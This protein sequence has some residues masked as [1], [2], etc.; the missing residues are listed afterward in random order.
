MKKVTI[1]ELKDNLSAIL[2]SA[3]RGE[4]IVVF[5]RKKP[6]VKVVALFE[7]SKSSSSELTLDRVKQL[8]AEGL[9]SR[10]KLNSLKSLLSRKRPKSKASVVDALIH[11]RDRDL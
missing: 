4:E 8:E 1:T 7:N 2:A 6:Y 3:S 5:D 10:R 11:D 9:V